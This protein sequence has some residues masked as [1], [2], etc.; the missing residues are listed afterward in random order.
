[1][2]LPVR[3]KTDADATRTNQLDVTG[4]FCG[5]LL[6]CPASVST[7]RQSRTKSRRNTGLF[8]YSPSSRLAAWRV[9]RGSQL[10]KCP[11]YRHKTKDPSG[12]TTGRVKLYGRL[13]G[14]ALAPNT[15]STGRD[16]R[17]HL[18]WSLR[19]AV[20]SK[21]PA[22]FFDFLT[23]ISVRKIIAQRDDWLRQRRTFRTS[24]RPQARSRPWSREHPAGPKLFQRQAYSKPPRQALL[25][26]C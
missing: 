9:C 13:G 24:P 20:R 15:A 3:R 6:L 8:P 19:V 4:I 14:W 2:N 18:Y 5:K 26:P 10:R 12:G 25:A 11:K 16:Y 23:G 1:M 7:A 17:S 21:R 22:I